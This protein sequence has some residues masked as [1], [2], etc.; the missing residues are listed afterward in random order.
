MKKDNIESLSGQTLFVGID[1]HKKSF[2]VTLRT[3]DCEMSSQP[4][5]KIALNPTCVFMDKS[6]PP[7]VDSGVGLFLPVRWSTD[8]SPGP[9]EASERTSEARFLRASNYPLILSGSCRLNLSAESCVTLT[10]LW[11]NVTRSDPRGQA[12]SIHSRIETAQ[13]TVRKR[14]R[15]FGRPRNCA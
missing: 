10:S 12:A 14:C 1:V 15:I 13:T 7:I 4:M 11:R 6:F 2:H 3:F 9:G 5:F 8:S